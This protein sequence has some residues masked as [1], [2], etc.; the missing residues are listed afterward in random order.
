MKIPKQMLVN[1][2]YN[3]AVSGIVK[4]ATKI[5]KPLKMEKRFRNIF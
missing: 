4:N 2:N 1:L 5:L 3:A